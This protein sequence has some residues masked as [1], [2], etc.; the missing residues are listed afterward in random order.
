MRVPGGNGR[1]IGVTAVARVLPSDWDVHRWLRFLAGLALLA[2]AFTAHL[3]PARL[4]TAAPAPVVAVAGVAPAPETA[5]T[6]QVATPSRPISTTVPMLV[7]VLVL[8]GLL[9]RRVRAV[10]GPP[11]RTL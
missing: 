11:L 3:A 2:L 1:L 5:Q 6:A 4:E 10:R 9:M 7:T 8:T